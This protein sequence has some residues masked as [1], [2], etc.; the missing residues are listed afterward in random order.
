MPGANPPSSGRIRTQ[1]R[2]YRSSGVQELQ[3]AGIP[4]VSRNLRALN[5]CLKS[6]SPHLIADFMDDASLASP[7]VVVVVLVLD[8]HERGKC[9]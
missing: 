5:S 8:F 1:F 4:F 6:S 3:N 7:I 9:T 2:I